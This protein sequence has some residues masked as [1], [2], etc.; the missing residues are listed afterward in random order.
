MY[1]SWKVLK[2]CQR[3]SKR[4]LILSDSVR[5]FENFD[6]WGD[7]LICLLINTSAPS[8]WL[9]SVAWPVGPVLKFRDILDCLVF[10]DASADELAPERGLA[11]QTWTSNRKPDGKAPVTWLLEDFWF[12]GK[13]KSSILRSLIYSFLANCFHRIPNYCGNPNL[14]AGGNTSTG[15]I[16]SP[17]LR[18]RTNPL[19]SSRRILRLETRPN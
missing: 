1:A 7:V 15:R 11:V 14:P 17:G 19:K 12:A 10:A 4:W 16:P 5:C 13:V 2:I 6:H 9:K 18:D 3:A 8:H